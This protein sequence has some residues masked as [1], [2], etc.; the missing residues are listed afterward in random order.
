MRHLWANCTDSQPSTPP[1]HYYLTMCMFVTV[2]FF[3]LAIHLSSSRPV[4]DPVSPVLA[5]LSQ[6]SFSAELLQHVQ[7]L[8]DPKMKGRAPGTEGETMAAQYLAS[9][10]G[11]LGFRVQTQRVP[12]LRYSVTQAS[13]LTLA[14]HGSRA[15]SLT[16][17]VDYVGSTLTRDLRVALAALPAV[18]AGYG[19]LDAQHGH[20]D[21]RSLDVRG[22]AVVVLAGQPSGGAFAG[23]PLTYAGRWTSKYEVGMQQGAA[24]VLIVHTTEKAGYPWEVVV[25]SNSGEQV[26]SPETPEGSLQVAGWISQESGE[27]LARMCDTTLDAWFAAAE[28]DT[29]SAAMPVSVSVDLQSTF[30]DFEG[31]NVLALLPGTQDSDDAVVVSGHLDHLGVRGGEVCP[32]AIDNASGCSMTLLMA[33]A[34]MQ[35]N[36]SF[37][38]SILFFFPTAEESGLLGSAF[39]VGNSGSIKPLACLNFDIGNV[40][41]P[42]HD[43]SLLGK[44]KSNLAAAFTQAAQAEG[45]TV[46]GDPAPST[47]LFF[48]SDHFSFAKAGIPGVWMYVGHSFVDQP[49]DYY[50][51]TVQQGYFNSIYHTPRDKFSADFRPD[52][53]IQQCRVCARVASMIAYDT[54]F[55]P[56]C[57]TSCI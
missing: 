3:L 34:F 32:G 18:F 30:M 23:L 31:K 21:Y 51:K 45:M 10:L 41:G 39:F 27:Q 54:S 36:V 44:D 48:R 8:S 42:T 57:D 15:L 20:D 53:L 38:R 1:P 24:A 35:A 12:L 2:L 11:P 19:I 55:T 40:W 56:E 33:K 22:K 17:G 50:N 49:P 43:I 4:D 47:G 5:L 28:A 14:P 6:P 7:V 52:G 16:Y 37:A 29:A 26:R 25:R 46:S 9:Q 13:A